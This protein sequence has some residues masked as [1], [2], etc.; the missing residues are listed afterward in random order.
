[1][2][3]MV[4]TGIAAVAASIIRFAVLPHLETFAAFSLAIGLWLVPAGA[5]AGNWRSGA[6]TYMAAYFVPLLAPENQMSYD[7]AQFYNAALAILAGIGAAALS[8]RL[9]PPLSPEFC[10]RRLLALTLR[11]L[12]R[13]AMGRTFGD[14]MGH[15]HGR[16]SAMPRGAI[17]LQRAQLLASL[18]V[19]SE[20]VGLRPLARRLG[21][22]TDFEHALAALAEGESSIAIEHLTRLDAALAGN[23]FAQREVVQA[24]AR[25]L[26]L[27][28][29]LLEHADYFDSG[30]LT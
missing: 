15:I 11:D 29:V 26:T 17:P 23:R 13:L 20:I 27:S 9:L 22:G 12:R 25:I 16:L 1:M 2:G 10:A 24:R 6:L 18:S 7:A 8:F 21:V 14:W 28:E 30:A 4:G 19:G 5:A 3:F